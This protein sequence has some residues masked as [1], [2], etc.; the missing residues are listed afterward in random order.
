[1]YNH[2]INLRAGCIYQ[3][4]IVDQYDPWKAIGAVFSRYDV[5]QMK[6]DFYK[7]FKVAA[8][9][10]R[11]YITE[12]DVLDLS[13]TY[14]HLNDLIEGFFFAAKEKGV[15]TEIAIESPL[16]PRQWVDRRQSAQESVFC[17]CS[18]YE[19]Y[20]IREDLW[21]MFQWG[22]SEES[23]RQTK[24]GRRRMIALFENITDL[25]SAAYYMYYHEKKSDEVNE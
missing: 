12:N 25:V 4:R 22:L 3:C 24:K 23:A 5:N 13:Y 17:L 10:L 6:V 2:E 19:P 14:E 9:N 7:M 11:R 18:A 15:I 8:L 1:M 21:D 16:F 20:E